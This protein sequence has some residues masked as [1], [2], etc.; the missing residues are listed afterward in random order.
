MYA[1]WNPFG[2]LDLLRQGID[3]LFANIWPTGYGR[4][5]VFLPGRSARGYPLLN[6]AA[7]D[8]EV[9]VN[10]FAPGLDPKSL[11]VSVERNVLT[12]AGEKKPLP[13]VKPEQYHRNERATG[14]FIRKLQL[15]LEVDEEKVQAHYENGILTIV[16]PKSEVALPRKIDILVK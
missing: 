6:I 11:E 2:E 5:S 7:D 12:I 15:D 4:R 3:D 1:N 10:A 9:I 8:D 14:K 13:G 16:L